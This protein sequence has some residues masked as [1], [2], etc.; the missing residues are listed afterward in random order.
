MSRPLSPGVAFGCSELLVAVS[1]NV[2]T[3][4]GVLSLSLGSAP[5]RDV[6]DATVAL[7]WIETNPEGQ[8]SATPRGMRALAEPDGRRRLRLLVF[9]HVEAENPPW[10]HLAPSGRRDTLMHAPA[11]VRQVLVEAGL[12][13]GD[14]DETVSFWDGLSARARGARDA[15]LSG[16]GRRGERLTVEREAARTGQP[17]KWIAL[18]SASDGYDV[19][20]RISADDPRWLTIEVKASERPVSRAEFHLTRNEW[21][22][23]G[24]ALNHA[25]HLWDLSG[26]EPLLAV[27]SVEHISEH[28]PTDSGDGCWESVGIPFRAFSALF[29]AA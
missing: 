13:Y 9:D 24:E 22:M 1:R 2:L 10:L 23:A 8:L 25:F 26:P 20:S 19:L 17:P 11:G 14:D 29:T 12:A 7:R 3:P 27:I 4:G 5:P 6:L 28:V 16:I 15:T 18:D 21:D